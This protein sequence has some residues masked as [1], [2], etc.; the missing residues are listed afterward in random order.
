MAGYVRAK[1][2]IFR[3]G[4]RPQTAVIGVDDSH[5]RAIHRSLKRRRTGILA[6]ISGQRRVAGGVWVAEGTLIDDLEGRAQ[7]AIDL[8][9]VATLPGVHNWQ[10]AAAA[11]AAARSV[12]LSPPMI[13]DGMRDY[14]GLRHRQELVA[15]A[16]GI[17][18][19]N[20]SKA[21]NPES[22]AK[23]LAC[24]D[25]ILWIAGGQPKDASLEPLLPYL[26]RIAHAYLI[27][28]AEDR[29]AAFLDGKVPYSHCG[30]LAAAVRA[31]HAAALTGTGRVVLLSPACASF[32]QFANFEARGERFRD[33]VASLPEVAQTASV[34]VS[35]GVA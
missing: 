13:A 21:T 24:Y 29:F 14:P 7:P 2:S 10:N 23:A 3:Q 35:G 32:D 30:T 8:N 15:A 22:A 25:G 18:Y 19:V 6:A 34:A 1:R 20:D 4:A 16:E 17:R 33:L 26:D 12:G 31:A 27:G 11:Y 9:A 28:D 5:C